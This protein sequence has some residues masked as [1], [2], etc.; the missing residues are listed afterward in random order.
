[1]RSL[2]AFLLAFFLPCAAMA[3][4]DVVT[5]E[6]IPVQGLRSAQDF[7]FDLKIDRRFEAI[8]VDQRSK[9]RVAYYVTGKKKPVDYS[10]LRMG[11]ELG[12]ASLPVR[13]EHTGEV[14]FPKLSDDQWRSAKIIANVEKGALKPGYK[15]NIVPPDSPMTLSYLREGAAQAKPAWKRTYGNALYG[16]TVPDFTCAKFEFT[17]PQPV[18]VVAPDARVLW[19]ASGLEV[20]VPLNDP[21][22]PP[23]A[24]IRFDRQSLIRIGGCKLERR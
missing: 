5:L 18:R 11:V 12:G 7:T 19:S 15:V 23:Q 4:D 2:Q 1:M 8:P 14:V 3:A 22:L 21:G 17:A 9:L 16:S 24:E 10:T 6:A 20:Q 13:V